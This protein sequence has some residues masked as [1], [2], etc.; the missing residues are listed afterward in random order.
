MVSPSVELSQKNLRGKA[1]R[2]GIFR[3]PISA[4]SVAIAVVFA[5]EIGWNRIMDAI[6]ALW[7][8]PVETDGEYG[9]CFANQPLVRSAAAGTAGTEVFLYYDT[10][11]LASWSS[12]RPIAIEPWLLVRYITH[13]AAP[14]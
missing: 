11:I 10:N 7:R 9:Y 13:A 8:G 4:M 1:F 14:L 5:T 6:V 2:F 12:A 3:G